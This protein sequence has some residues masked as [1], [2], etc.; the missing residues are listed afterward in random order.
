MGMTPATAGLL[1]D[2]VEYDTGLRHDAETT[3]RSALLIT[4]S[5]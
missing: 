3:R 1:I 2:S 5:W 4:T